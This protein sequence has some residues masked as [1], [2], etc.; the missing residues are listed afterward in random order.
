VE[1][2]DDEFQN[3]RQGGMSVEQSAVEFNRL[4]KY[5]RQMVDTEQNR[6]RQFIKGLRLELGRALAP[7][8]PSNYSTMVNSA[9]RTENKIS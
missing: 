4:S 7:F 2:R 5:Y 6:I 3:L 9:T 1:K 8:P